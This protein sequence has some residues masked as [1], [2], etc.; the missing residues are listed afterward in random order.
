M[1]TVK[2]CPRHSDGTG[3]MF[4]S[5]DGTWYKCSQEGCGYEEKI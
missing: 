1:E 3:V 2:R 4:L 5:D